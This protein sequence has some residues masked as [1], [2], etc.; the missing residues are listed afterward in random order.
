MVQQLLLQHRLIMD[1]QI[2]V[3]RITTLTL[4]ISPS[5]FDCTNIG[6][7]T[8]TLTVTDE[9]GNSSTCTTTVTVADTVAPTATC[10]ADFTVQ[11]DAS[12]AATITTAQI[13]NGSTDNCTADNAT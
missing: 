4:A 2:I 9:S 12:G 5:S 13:N 11:L 8:V 10:A 6:A 1:Q 7:N 3:Q